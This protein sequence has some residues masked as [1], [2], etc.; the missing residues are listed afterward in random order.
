M[1]SSYGAMLRPVCPT[2]V[3]VPWRDSRYQGLHVHSKS[4][5]SAR[6]RKRSSEPQTRL[7]RTQRGLHHNRTDLRPSEPAFA[8]PEVVFASSEEVFEKA[9]TSSPNRR[10][11]TGEETW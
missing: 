3:E 4:K 8:T 7:R 6:R 1:R 5:Y 11:H 2:R 10:P 9:K